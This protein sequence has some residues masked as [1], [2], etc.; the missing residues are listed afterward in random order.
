M[1]IELENSELGDL[2]EQYAQIRSKLSEK[3]EAELR[4]IDHR[5]T[6]LREERQKES[7]QHD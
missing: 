1:K 5:L 7:L 2:L 3:I 6:I 4:N